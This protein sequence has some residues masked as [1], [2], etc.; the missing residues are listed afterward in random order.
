MGGC[1]CVRSTT[2]AAVAATGAAA[3]AADAFG[4]AAGIRLR[5]ELL[6]SIVY[7]HLQIAMQRPIS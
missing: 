7:R 5:R 3:S 6:R 1:F 2:V 4:E